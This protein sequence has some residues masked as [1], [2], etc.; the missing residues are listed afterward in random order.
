MAV[1]AADILLAAQHG[2][3]RPRTMLQERLLALACPSSLP[4]P[5]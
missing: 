4:H 1:A 5:L 2:G 3:H